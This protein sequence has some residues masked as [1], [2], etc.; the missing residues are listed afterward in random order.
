MKKTTTLTET[1]N[2]L[3]GATIDS[4]LKNKKLTEENS[5]AIKN[6]MNSSRAFIKEHGLAD[7]AKLKKEPVN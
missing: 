1:D 6:K 4:E 7:I 5:L 3:L 2:Q